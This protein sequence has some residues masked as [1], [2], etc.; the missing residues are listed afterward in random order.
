MRSSRLLQVLLVAFSLLCLTM[1]SLWQVQQVSQAQGSGPI[2]LTKTLNRPTNV[3]RVGEVLTFTIA[4]TNNS[5]F[6]LTGVTLIDTYD[7]TTLGYAGAIP[8]ESSVNPGAGIVTWNNVAVPPI[9]PG[10]SIIVTVVFTAEHPRTAIVN[11]VRA[12][13]IIHQS[14]Q[15][16]FTTETSQTQDAI[17]GSAPVV[18]F[19]APGATPQAGLPVTF[20]H[21][22]TNDGAAL[23]TYLPLTD[24]YDPTYLDFLFA[25]PTPTITNPP[26]LLVWDD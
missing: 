15:L 3:V 26:G 23:M 5:A 13:D 20:T 18:K 19:L 17:G 6:T 10:Q 9:P 25:I 11:A 16:T 12:Q 7:N 8:P 4:L 24:T 2:I 1:L 14:G 22:I 21:I